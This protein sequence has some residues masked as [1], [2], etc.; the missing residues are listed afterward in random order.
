MDVQ[1]Q[2]AKLNFKLC[3]SHV[4]NYFVLNARY[5]MF[6]SIQTQAIMSFKFKIPSHKYPNFL[7]N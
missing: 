1:L 7:K 4:K 2:I 3:V 5:N 6:K